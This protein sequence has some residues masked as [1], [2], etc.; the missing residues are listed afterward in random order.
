MAMRRRA[1]SATTKARGPTSRGAR[2]P[3]RGRLQVAR[4][5]R[6]GRRRRAPRPPGPQRRRPSRQG[7]RL[8]GARGPPGEAPGRRRGRAARPL[9]LQE[10]LRQE[11]CPAQASRRG[12]RHEPSLHA[13]EEAAELTRGPR[14]IRAAAPRAGGS[15]REG[16]RPNPRR[17]RRGGCPP[18]RAGP[19]AR[20]AQ[21][22]RS[23][24]REVRP[25]SAPAGSRAAPR[26]ARPSSRSSTAPEA[27]GCRGSRSSLRIAPSAGGSAASSG[28]ASQAI[29]RTAPASLS[30]VRS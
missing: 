20:R 9:G 28:A 15:F 17:A 27:K 11:G 13:A 23:H 8:Q 30:S 5:A 19:S 24:C 7:R 2:M 10:G 29:T 3:P 26:R 25:A 4:Q 12:V 22:S 18:T 14:A 1:A 21:N 6:P 16:A